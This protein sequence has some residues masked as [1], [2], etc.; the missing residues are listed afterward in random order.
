M[1]KLSDYREISDPAA[2]S[3]Q[4]LVS[5]HML[6]YRHERFLAEAIEGVIAQVCDFPIELIIAEDCSPDGTLVIALDYQ[7]RYPHL[8]RVITGDRNVGMH[9]N[10][11]R[12]IPAARGKYIALCEGDDYW[13]HPHK[14][15]MQI[16]L[17]TAHPDMTFCHTD[18]DRKTRFRTRRCRHKNHPSK[19]LAHGAAYESLLHEWSVMTATTV[20][21][22]DIL[23]LFAHTEFANPRWPFG[24]YNLLLFSSLHG[25]AGYIDTS[26]A[27]F[28]KRRGSAGNNGH[29]AH[30]EMKLAA[31]ECVDLFLAKHPVDAAN[32]RQIHARLK[33]TIYHAAFYAERPDVMKSAYGWLRS[34]GFKPSSIRHKA[35]LA[36]IALKFPVRIL[37]AVKNF[38]NLYLSAIPA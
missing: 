9:A 38:V 18:F 16:G 15:Q 27:T 3:L 24:D 35:C 17:M 13:H 11:A 2:M 36:A 22:S 12:S 5:V 10:A 7:R 8:I 1:N 20:F 19:W 29:S 25:I 33:R 26:T 14:L 4:P 30:L 31:Q 23:A 21:R 28:R 32:D 6:A 34:S 37:G